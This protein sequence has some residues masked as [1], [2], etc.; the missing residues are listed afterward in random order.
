MRRRDLLWSGAAALGLVGR[1]DPQSTSERKP[2][3][4]PGGAKAAVS[5]TYDDGLNSQL[6]NVVPMLSRFD[7]KATFFLTGMN[8]EPRVG[9]WRK[10]GEAGHE[11]GNHTTHHL[12]RLHDISPTVFDRQEI[13]DMEA[14][15]AANFDRGRVPIYAYPCGVLQLGKGGEVE[16]QLRYVRLLK[17]H[18]AAARAAL[19]EPNDPRFVVER[20]YA[21]QA[22]APTYYLD[23]P[24][25]ATDYV[26]SAIASGR[27]AILIFHNVF[28]SR[29]ADGDTSLQ[30][31][32]T[33]LS[34]LVAQPIWCAPMG[35]VLRRLGVLHESSPTA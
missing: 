27:W 5:L 25:L 11:I 18:F 4:W 35:A 20:R 12:C 10:V 22:T 34:W 17:A 15:L 21:L 24:R 26:K 2:F 16:E 1:A 9:D 14:Y 29:R 7:L 6:D 19:G 33:I 28:D 8:I 32:E 31:H 3:V 13:E 23:D 30:T